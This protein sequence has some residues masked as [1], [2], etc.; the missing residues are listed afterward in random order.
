VRVRGGLGIFFFIALAIIIILVIMVGAN[1]I[2]SLSGSTRELSSA[3]EL[4]RKTNLL[5]ESAIEEA[6]HHAIGSDL[7][8]P[9][10]STGLFLTMRRFVGNRTVEGGE[11][12]F[13]GADRFLSA[14]RHT[15][16]LTYGEY[17]DDADLQLVETRPDR[18]PV[19]YGVI[20]AHAFDGN[21]S[22]SNESWGVI[23]FA[24]SATVKAPAMFRAIDRAAVLSKAYKAVLIGPPWPF[25]QY[26][27]FIRNDPAANHQPVP[28][29]RQALFDRFAEYRTRYD[30]LAAIVTAFNQR[31][32][33]RGVAGIELPPFPLPDSAGPVVC[34]TGSV[35][36]AD[37]VM[38][39]Y[40]E[41]F[42][43]IP[44]PLPPVSAV[45]VDELLN[46]GGGGVRAAAEAMVAYR[47]RS[48]YKLR[49]LGDEEKKLWFGSDA[50]EVAYRALEPAAFRNKATRLYRDV[51]DLAQLSR[52]GVLELNGVYF[53][54]ASLT[55]NHAYRGRGI[56][57][58]E[59]ADGGDGVKLLKLARADPGDEESHAV[60]VSWKDIDLTGLASPGVV[61][62]DLLAPRGTLLGH[63]GKTVRGAVLV[64][65]LTDDPGRQIADEADL[66]RDGPTIARPPGHIHR[67]WTPG[68]SS[69]SAELARA[70][71]V[72]VDPGYVKKR[73]W[74]RREVER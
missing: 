21:V 49:S 36:P 5:V 29:G 64:N 55:L 45:N 19:H 65:H 57:F 72:F 66:F 34:T 51:A 69:Y 41:P 39:A 25:Y 20:E 26:A 15:P 56:L 52:S 3:V 4:G 11:P 60:V 42:R 48:G 7:N 53:V 61:E 18:N 59:A 9:A 68:S 24:H 50:A 74:A 28:R 13:S 71:R 33:A 23:G 2:T 40:E 22:Q 62:A 6:V 30:W 31:A 54:T 37:V 8:Q 10:S 16:A 12:V 1:Q 27:L 38:K 58:C 70:I 44:T 63:A 46:R 14:A 43:G 67:P 73:Y 35:A 32:P 47:E 17:K